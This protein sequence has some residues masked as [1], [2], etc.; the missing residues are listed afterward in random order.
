MVFLPLSDPERPNLPS[1][2]HSAYSEFLINQIPL[3]TTGCSYII[4]RILQNFKLTRSLI[5]RSNNILEVMSDPERPGDA[6]KNMWCLK[7]GMKLQVFT[8][9]E[10]LTR[11]TVTGTTESYY[12]LMEDD[13]CP[14]VLFGL[15]FLYRGTKNPKIIELYDYSRTGPALKTFQPEVGMLLLTTQTAKDL[16]DIIFNQWTKPNP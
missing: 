15:R 3:I 7:N 4:F 10:Y 1:R 6:P 13:D 9:K 5:V 11:K 12:T 2:N 8:S 16:N 14:F